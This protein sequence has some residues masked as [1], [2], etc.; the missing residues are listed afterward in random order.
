MG[1]EEWATWGKGCRFK[2]LEITELPAVLELAPLETVALRLDRAAGRALR[3]GESARTHVGIKPGEGR[4]KCHSVCE[5]QLSSERRKPPDGMFNAL[6]TLSR[7]RCRIS[8]LIGLSSPPPQESLL[9][10]RRGDGRCCGPRPPAAPSHLQRADA[11][12]G[13]RGGGAEER[14][15]GRN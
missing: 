11:A 3:P 8:I 4:W 7:S 2:V 6:L 15:L 14:T 9:R 12:W 10:H 5:A 1:A 13:V